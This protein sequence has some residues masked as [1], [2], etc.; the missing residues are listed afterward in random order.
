MGHCLYNKAS[1]YLQS[2]QV[3]DSNDGFKTKLL[4]LRVPFPPWDD[5][6]RSISDRNLQ[7][8]AMTNHSVQLDSVEELHKVGLVYDC[9][10]RDLTEQGRPCY[11]WVALS[12]WLGPWPG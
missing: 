6:V 3:Q 10:S 4:I 8:I 7:L 2:P 12:P 5:L 1:H 9:V 11:K